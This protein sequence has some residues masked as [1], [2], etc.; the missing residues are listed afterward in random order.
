MKPVASP[1]YV[2]LKISSFYTLNV[3]WGVVPVGWKFAVVTLCVRGAE[4]T[5]WSIPLM[6]STSVN[7]LHVF[8]GKAVVS[9]SVSLQNLYF[10]SCFHNSE[11]LGSVENVLQVVNIVS[12]SL[13]QVREKS[14]KKTSTGMPNSVWAFIKSSHVK[15]QKKKMTVWTDVNMKYWNLN[16]I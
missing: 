15:T 2:P 9:G 16:T 7:F 12:E 11:E 4:K 8:G 3:W 13:F 5:R 14:W 1:F 10:A 6:W